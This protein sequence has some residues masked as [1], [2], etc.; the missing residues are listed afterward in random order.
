MCEFKV[1]LEESEQRKEIT[2]NIVKAK[3]KDGKV[4]LMD[5]AGDIMKVDG[6]RILVV[7][8]LMQELV[9]KKD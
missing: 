2:K 1:F 5:S 9:L 4:V 7:D 6:A 3:L 8:T